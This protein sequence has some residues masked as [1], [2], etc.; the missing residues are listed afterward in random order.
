MFISEISCC[1]CRPL[2]GCLGEDSQL[3]TTKHGGYLAAAFSWSISIGSIGGVSERQL[4]DILESTVY[5][6]LS[7]N[8]VDGGLTSWC[9]KHF[10]FYVPLFGE[11]IQF[12]EYFFWDGLKP[13]TSN[14]L[15]FIISGCCCCCLLLGAT[16][17]HWATITALPHCMA[18]EKKKK[19]KRGQQK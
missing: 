16:T 10:D 11:I 18:A 17:R 12:D 8:A 4:L 14:V 15:L 7:G 9:F 2:F 3:L 6:C 5:L 13:P 1:F 19:K